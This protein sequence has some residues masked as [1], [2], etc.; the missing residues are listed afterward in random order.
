[1]GQLSAHTHLLGKVVIYTSQ[2]GV[3]Y[4]NSFLSEIFLKPT[5]TPKSS[6]APKVRELP[7][8]RTPARCRL[9]S[10]GVSWAGV[11]EEDSAVHQS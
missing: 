8:C 1:M 7:K 6:M 2:Y 4:E 3:S 9:Q 5:T 10:I 11:M